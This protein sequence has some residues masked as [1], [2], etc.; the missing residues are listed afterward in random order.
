MADEMATPT[1]L[2]ISSR[3]AGDESLRDFDCNRPIGD[4][5]AFQ[6]VYQQRQQSDGRSRPGQI[7][8]LDGRARSRLRQF[9]KPWSAD[10][11][12]QRFAQLV[13]SQRNLVWRTAITTFQAEGKSIVRS[14]SPNQAFVTSRIF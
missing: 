2:A 4:A 8:D 9:R 3:V 12:A 5:A 11:L 10:R 13:L 6:F 14:S 7:I 1:F